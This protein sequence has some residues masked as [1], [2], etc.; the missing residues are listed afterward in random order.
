MKNR[1]YCLALDLKDDPQLIET[2]K[3]YH[4]P[5]GAWPE[6]TQSLGDAGIMDMGNL[7]DGQSVIHDHGSG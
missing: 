2:Y 4:A 6:V 7:L 1:R 3:K 5:G